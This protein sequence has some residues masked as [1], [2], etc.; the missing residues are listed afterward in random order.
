MHPPPFVHVDRHW[1]PELAPWLRHEVTTAV[2]VVTDRQSQLTDIG[3]AL[4]A[5]KR[6]YLDKF[7]A[8]EALD[9]C[10]RILVSRRIFLAIV[11]N[12]L[13][14]LVCTTKTADILGLQNYK[15]Y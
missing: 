13:I 15:K 5:Q 10:I 8:P 3:H 2:G 14:L 7:E 1:K 11:Q 6:P 4:W 12:R 9:R